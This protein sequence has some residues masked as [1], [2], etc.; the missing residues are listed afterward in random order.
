VT[1][2]G[3]LIVS[4][5]QEQYG[6]FTVTTFGNH[7][8]TNDDEWLVGLTL[9]SPRFDVPSLVS[10]GHITAASSAAGASERNGG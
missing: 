6:N 9:V 3:G 5:W 8:G 4:V 7:D 2:A 10:G 1:V